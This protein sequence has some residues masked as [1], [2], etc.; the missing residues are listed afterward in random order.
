MDNKTIAQVITNSPKIQEITYDFQSYQRKH[1][2]YFKNKDEELKIRYENLQDI[3]GVLNTENILYWLQG[4]TM[5]GI[6]KNGALL[7][8]DSDEDIG[9]DVSSLYDVCM[10][11]VPKLQTMGF[12]VIR[13]TRNNS[14]ISFMRNNRYLDICVFRRNGDHYFY[15]Q[16]NFPVEYYK[17]ISQIKVKDFVYR[18]PK[19]SKEICY[20]SYKL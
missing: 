14:M 7:E 19:L 20:Y 1:H 13:A 2:T 12:T 6:F 15:E 18:I 9:V 10:K 5:L 17:E 3:I 8:N 16:K 11:V 4:K